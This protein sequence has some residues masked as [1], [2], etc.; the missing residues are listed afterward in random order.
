MGSSAGEGCGKDIMHR[1]LLAML[2][3]P[4]SPLR[5]FPVTRE[6]RHCTSDPKLRHLVRNL[7]TWAV[8]DILREVGSDSLGG[9]A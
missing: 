9:Q 5:Y 3:R 8:D 2:K 1:L 4:A 7:L 6:R